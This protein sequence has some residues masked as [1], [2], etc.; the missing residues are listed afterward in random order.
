MKRNPPP[1]GEDRHWRRV[2]FWTILAFA[3]ATGLGLVA[4]AQASFGTFRS[5]TISFWRMAEYWL[6]DYYLWASL[7]PFVLWLGRRFP[8]DRERWPGHLA[9]HLMAAVVVAQVELLASCWVIGRIAAVPAK[10]GGVW[11]Y[12]VDIAG[13]YSLWGLIIYLFI[14]AAGQAYHYY[15]SLSEREL[16]AADLRRQVVEAQLRAL[17]MQLHPHFLFNTLHSIGGLIR[18][19]RSEAALGM[20]AG[21]GDLL[22]YSLENEERLEIPLEEEIEFVRRYL[23]VERTRFSDRLAVEIEAGNRVL[24]ASVPNMILQPLVENALQHGIA[25][26]SGRRSLKVS[27]RRRGRF[28]R[29]EVR[30]DGPH[31]DDGWHPDEGSGVG[32]RNVRERLW[33]LYGSAGRLEVAAAPSAGVVSVI[34]L[35]WKE[36]EDGP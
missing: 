33:R 30:D 7:C 4:T 15:R 14:L 16:E 32:L 23:E 24:R 34:D 9:L 21:L 25:P 27:A 35:P 29:L 31:R 11:D 19:G 20:L 12:Y 1:P 13:S 6:P 17:R 36:W 3:A 28:L 10:Y 26:C 22:R 2:A 5:E 18:T 8:L